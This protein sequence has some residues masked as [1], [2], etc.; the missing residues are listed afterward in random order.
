ML[1][2][3][4]REL[5]KTAGISRQRLGA[6]PWLAYQTMT[7][8]HSNVSLSIQIDVFLLALEARQYSPA[9]VSTYAIDLAHLMERVG[10]VDPTGLS[11]HDIRRALATLHGRGYQPRTLA[12]TLSAWRSF[13]KHLVHLELVQVNP[14]I[15]IRP[16]K[17]DKRLPNALSVGDMAKLLDGPVEGVL[18]IRDQA[19]FELMYS[20]GLRRAELI[21]LHLDS[22]DLREGEVRVIGKGGR[23][24]IVPVGKKA[25]AATQHWLARRSELAP[26]TSALFVGIRGDRIGASAL[27]LALNR[28]AEKR[29]VMARVHPHAL[30]HSFA[31]HMLQSS[32]NLRAVQEMLGHSSVSTTQIYTH[33]DMTHLRRAYQEAHPRALKRK[34]AAES[35]SEEAE[36]D[37]AHQPPAV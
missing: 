36:T 34:Q 25:V 21:G 4:R 8:T 16:P 33:L 5:I 7:T 6:T 20:S 14:G 3:I 19:M 13:F 11:S 9:T 24:R 10:D 12:R 23:T 35:L 22:V 37:A 28:L 31:S 1:V 18:E 30:R 32:G 15:G 26:D 2:K 17:G 27:R 29:G